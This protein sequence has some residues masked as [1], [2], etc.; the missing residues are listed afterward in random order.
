MKEDRN[1]RVEAENFLEAAAEV[2]ELVEVRLFDAAVEG[3]DGSK[4]L[5]D[6]F[7]VFRASHEFGH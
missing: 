2:G 4:L 5:L 6:L 7:E 3:D 1:W